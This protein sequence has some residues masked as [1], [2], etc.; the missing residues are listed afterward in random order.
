M[1]KSKWAEEFCV[2]I[3]MAEFNIKFA[4]RDFFN[5]QEDGYILARIEFSFFLKFHLRINKYLEFLTPLHIVYG[6]IVKKNEKKRSYANQEYG[7]YLN[8]HFYNSD[9]AG[10]RLARY[11]LYEDDT[12]TIFHASDERKCRGTKAAAQSPQYLGYVSQNYRRSPRIT[13]SSRIL[14]VYQVIDELW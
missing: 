7:G 11:I 13:D 3:K 14:P 1:D 4:D 5:G 9:S 10:A 2:V 6:K 8:N 12:I